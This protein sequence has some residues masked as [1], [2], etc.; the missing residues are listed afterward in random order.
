MSSALN[1]Q[2]L[3]AGLGG[4][5]TLIDEWTGHSGVRRLWESDPHL[6][7]GADE[8]RWTGWLDIADRQLRRPQGL[9]AL[10]NEVKQAGFRHIV[11]LGMGGSSLCPE[12]LSRTFGPQEGFPDLQILDSTDPGQLIS[13]ADSVD[14]ANTLFFVSSKSG[15]TLEPDIMRRHFFRRVGEILGRRPG[16]R[17]IAVTD[18]GSQLEQIAARDGY[19]HIFYGLPEIGGRYSALSNFGMAPA[20]AMGLDVAELLRRAQAMAEA[21]GPD[22]DAADNPG[23]ALGLLLGLALKKGRDKLTF[24]A[25]DGLVSLGGWLEQLIAEST[26]KLGKAIIPVD[27]ETPETPEAYADD[28]VFVELALGDDMPYA[29]QLTALEEAGHPI[30]RIRCHEAMNLGQEFFRW[31]VA[32]AVAGAVMGVNP[33]DQPD[34][35]ASKIATRRLTD[36]YEKTRALP[37]E[38]PF[39]EQDGVGLFADAAY[40]VSLA[41]A[42]E[43]E[44]S[45]TGYLKA[46]LDRL[47]PGDYLALLA[48]IEMDEGAGDSLQRMRHEIRDAKK[49]ATCLGFGPRFLHSTGQAYKG[50]PNSG[51]VMQITCDDRDD[52]DVPGR[53]YTF[54]VVKAAQARG[55]F[56][57]LCERG[58]RALRIHLTRLD[59]GLRALESA[60]EAAVR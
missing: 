43:G 16:D 60:V 7:T 47:K 14:L 39:F 51:V 27:L 21:C 42:V 30:V 1:D 36:E 15:S 33:F 56:Q 35:E 20:A 34:V 23:V 3:P 58:R 46:H 37:F 18:P 59:D 17:F 40:A 52:V 2:T 50:G 26:G 11:L 41:R 9:E 29:E 24:V 38:R 49:T 25:S 55:D 31:E 19:R 32:T 54:G 10:R 4:W 53:E 5:Q 13:V 45:L 22:V 8:S 6:W 57:V 12:V 28:R 44:E 48:Y